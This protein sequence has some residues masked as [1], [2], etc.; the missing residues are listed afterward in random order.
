MSSLC[1]NQTCLCINNYR[2]SGKKDFS[3]VIL[4]RK[5]FVNR[6]VVDEAISDNSSVV[7]MYPAKMK[8][9]QF[10]MVTLC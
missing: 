8:K 7:V 10:F 4:E 2:K 1:S 3:T 6:L 5:K 9:L